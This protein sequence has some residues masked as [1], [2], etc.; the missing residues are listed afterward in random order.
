MLWTGRLWTE[1]SWITGGVAVLLAALA[2]P[3]RASGWVKS[4]GGLG[5]I[6]YAFYLVHFPLLFIVQRSPLPSGT[7]PAYFLR[8]GVW[9][10][11][12][13]SLAWFL[14]Q[15]FQP[16]IKARLTRLNFT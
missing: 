1:P 6:S 7:I 4:F 10:G 16:W 2:L 13:L 3:W 8:I 15:R 14:E 5:S 11:L 9:A 12:A